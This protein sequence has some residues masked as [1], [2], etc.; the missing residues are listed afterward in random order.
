[1]LGEGEIIMYELEEQ[2]TTI[3]ILES[4]GEIEIYSC[5]P[6]RIEKLLQFASQ[7]R[8]VTAKIK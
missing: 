8:L 6:K 2:E 1:M 7:N 3:N 4:T 5:A